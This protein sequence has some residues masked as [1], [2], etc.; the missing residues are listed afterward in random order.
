[1]TKRGYSD[2]PTFSDPLT[3]EEAANSQFVARDGERWKKFIALIQE[4]DELRHCSL[5][6]G[7]RDGKMG[8]VIMRN[9]KAKYGYWYMI[10]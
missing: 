10:A 9:G 2:T 4:G 8:F 1:M 7:P 3:I 6:R 5:F